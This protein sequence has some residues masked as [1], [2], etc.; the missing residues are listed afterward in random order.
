M[1]KEQNDIN[2]FLVDSLALKSTILNSYNIES[3]NTKNA[4]YLLPGKL[5]T[6]LANNQ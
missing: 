3:L 1:V 2:F 5:Q 4:K 6:T